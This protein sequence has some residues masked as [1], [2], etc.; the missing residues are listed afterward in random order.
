M[1]RLITLALVTFWALPLN[2]QDLSSPEEEIS[3]L[4]IVKSL[5]AACVLK[6][7]Q[8][9]TDKYFALERLYLKFADSIFSDIGGKETFDTIYQVQFNSL[10]N[11]YLQG[12][13]VIDIDKCDSEMMRAINKSRVNLAERIGIAIPNS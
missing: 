12:F 8:E 3:Q 4:S 6:A 10:R 9:T 7:S 5:Y 2:A 11:A 1:K 13:Y